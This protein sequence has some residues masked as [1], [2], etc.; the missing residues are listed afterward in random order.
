[1]LANITCASNGGGADGGQGATAGAARRRHRALLA[2]SDS[3]MTTTGGSSC[4][5][6]SFSLTAL[7]RLPNDMGPQAVTELK[8][9]M[10]AAIDAWAAESQAAAAAAAAAGGSGAGVLL[11]C[12]PTDDSDITELTEVG[13]SGGCWYGPT[14]G[15]LQVTSSKFCTSVGEYDKAGGA[16][17]RCSGVRICCGAGGCST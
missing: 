3:G 12:G 16:M 5:S 1:M 2:S 4:S 14:Y 7:L 11:L 10:R 15:A 13:V 8:A 17:D 6:G 9:R